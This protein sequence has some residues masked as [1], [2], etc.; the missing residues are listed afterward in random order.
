MTLTDEGMIKSAHVTRIRSS[1][2]WLNVNLKELWDYKDLVYFFAWR[3]IKLRYKQTILGFLWAF[4]VPFVSMVIFS[5]FFGALAG[6]SSNGVPYPIFTYTALLPWTLFA[7]GMSRSTSSIVTNANIVKKVYFPRIILPGSSVISPLMDF[8]IAS[9]LLVGMFFFYHM[10]LTINVIWLPLFLLLAVI[11]SLGVGIWLTALNAYYR[12]FQYVVPFLVQIWMFASPVVYPSSLV[13]A[14]VQF[15]YGLNPMAG[16]I[17]GF[18]WCLLGSAMPGPVVL[19]SVL[20][21]LLLLA[22]GVLYFGKV[23]RNMADVV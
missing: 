22:S 11:T 7:E 3:D 1:R 2:R 9:L 8:F 23:E 18:R 10:S 5:L 14:N 20:I 13:P 16:V 4:I 6:I 12:D 19:V 15:L 21:S 17:E